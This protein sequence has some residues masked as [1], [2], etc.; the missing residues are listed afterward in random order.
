MELMNLR[1][2]RSLCQK[3]FQAFKVTP[4]GNASAQELFERV[5]VERATGST[6][7][8]REF[9]DYRVTLDGKELERFKTVVAI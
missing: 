4:M 5:K 3:K 6:L 1:L 8:A 9:S 2:Y 7:A